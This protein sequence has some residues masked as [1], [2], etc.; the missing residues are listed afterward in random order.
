MTGRIDHMLR[1]EEAG[2]AMIVAV[3]LLGVIG[4]LVALI[5]SVGTH[6]DFATGR[7]RNFVEALH[8]AESGVEQAV[9]KLQSTNGT[10]G[11]TFSG[12][13]NEGGNE[14]SYTVTVTK[15]PRKRF[16]I[17]ATGNVGTGAGL[18]T[19]RRLRVTMAPAPSF[20][21]ALFSYTS[22]STKNSAAAASARRR[23]AMVF[24]N[25]SR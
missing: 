23:R 5:L 17:D 7:G 13:I 20:K 12:T 3:I 24:D 9:S 15:L 2:F 22:V 10:Y 21:Y 19:R 25:H 14:G 4:T 18:K 1:R 11:G 6:S 16:Q 8:V